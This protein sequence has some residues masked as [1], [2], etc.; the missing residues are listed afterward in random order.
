M[1]T[2]TSQNNDFLL[3]NVPLLRPA[4]PVPTFTRTLPLLKENSLKGDWWDEN[5]RFFR[6][7]YSEQKLIQ[8]YNLIQEKHLSSTNENYKK[9]YKNI[10]S[11]SVDN[12]ISEINNISDA[13]IFQN[14]HAYEQTSKKVFIDC[15]QLLSYAFDVTFDYNQLIFR[16]PIDH[17][18]YNFARVSDVIKLVN[19]APQNI[20]IEFFANDTIHRIVRFDPKVIGISISS[21]FELVPAF[22]LAKLI[23]EKLNNKVHVVIGGNYF[24]RIEHRFRTGEPQKEKYKVFWKWMDSYIYSKGDHALLKLIK[25]IKNEHNLTYVPNLVYKTEDKIIENSFSYGDGIDILPQSDFGSILEQK[26]LY[27]VPPEY[28]TVPIYTSI[29]CSYAKCSFCA[30]DKMSGNFHAEL[31]IKKINGIKFLIGKNG[32]SFR[33]FRQANKVVKEMIKIKENN[34]LNYFSFNDETLDMDFAIELS[35]EIIQQKHKLYWQAFARVENELASLSFCNKL[36]EGGCRLLRMGFEYLSQDRLNQIRKGY[37]LKKQKQILKALNQAGIW[38]HAYFMISSEKDYNDA[39]NFFIN[40]PEYC[41]LIHTVE[42][43]S[44]VNE[45]HSLENLEKLKKGIMN[46]SDMDVDFPEFRIWYDVSPEARKFVKKLLQFSQNHFPIYKFLN[47]PSEV[48]YYPVLNCIHTLEKIKNHTKNIANSNQTFSVHNSINQ[49]LYSRN[50]QK[51]TVGSLK[52]IRRIKKLQEF[53]LNKSIDAALFTFSRDILYYTGTSQPS[54]LLITRDD[55]RLMVRRALDFVMNETFLEKEKITD[56]GSFRDVLEMLNNL[57]I[58]KGKLGLTFDVITADFFQ[59]VQKT[60]ENYE[61][62]N[63]SGKILEQRM[64]KDEEEIWAIKKACEIMD[65]GHQQ[66]LKTL[67]S[68]MTELELAAEV[69][70]AHRKNGH[71]GV[72]SMRNL[73]FYISRGPLSSGDNLLRVSGFAN[74]ITGVGLSSAVPAGPS[75]RKIKQNDLVIV[76]IP[77]C[78]NGY[79]CDQARTYHLGPPRNE[80]KDLFQRLREI[81]DISISS[82]KEGITCRELFELT[83]SASKKLDVY[84]YFLGYGVRKGNFI[85]HGIGLD[86]NEPPIIFYNSDFPLLKN[87]VLTTEIHLTNPKWGAVKLEDVVLVKENGC[88]ILTLTPREL[89]VI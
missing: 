83:V 50:L 46:S 86:A 68:G 61:L 14:I 89:F 57:L 62:I 33:F 17:E 2:L 42:F 47:E 25:S 76:D 54:L 77:T 87:F 4:W 88:D 26:D 79:H 27:F 7:F 8:A 21:A 15:A 22:S 16:S 28:L 66:V 67:H 5:I 41:D 69:E 72:L 19:G 3:L 81:S 34:N 63:I 40:E 75:H 85:G 35:Q 18:G 10:L 51:V 1:K 6:Y 38:V 13:K 82:I 65:T 53:L 49:N 32:E 23:K 48:A 64:Q 74:T 11:L 70:Y 29:G 55:Y 31:G 71:E 37:S 43:F 59:K 84:D 44:Q 9:I 52:K 24:S 60:F 73:D 78:Y 58:K 39:M 20:T 30:I 80:I 56:K 12:L 45:R 36:Y